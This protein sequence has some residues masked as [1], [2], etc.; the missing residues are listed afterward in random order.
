MPSD[1]RTTAVE[2][3][4]PLCYGTRLSI[5][6]Q[7]WPDPAITLPPTR[8]IEC[9]PERAERHGVVY[10]APRDMTRAVVA[11]AVDQARSSWRRAPDG[12]KAKEAVATALRVIN[13]WNSERAADD[14]LDL[15]EALRAVNAAHA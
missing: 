6:G 2:R 4:C 11:Y 9:T 10:A 13:W 8:C 12:D 5:Q 1:A 3:T 15:A 7:G 14:R